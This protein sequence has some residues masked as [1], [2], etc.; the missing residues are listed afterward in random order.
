MGANLGPCIFV[1]FLTSMQ[2]LRPLGCCAPLFQKEVSYLFSWCWVEWIDRDGE[3]TSGEGSD[4]T[5]SFRSRCGRTT[6]SARLE[7]GKMV[8]MVAY[9]CHGAVAQSVERPLKVP[10]WP[11]FETRWVWMGKKC[12]KGGIDTCL[13][14]C[15]YYFRPHLLRHLA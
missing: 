12:W 10:V 8:K 5:C 7:S 6:E 9:R 13:R 2:R 1:Y 4:T 14:W 15:L 3:K 11:G